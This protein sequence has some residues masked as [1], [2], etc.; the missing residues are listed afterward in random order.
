MCSDSCAICQQ[1][2]GNDHV[3]TCNLRLGFGNL[4][5]PEHGIAHTA[6]KEAR[7]GAIDSFP[8]LSLSLSPPLF[9][10]IC[11]SHSPSNSS[12]CEACVS[13]F[14]SHTTCDSFRS[15][16]LFAL[17]LCAPLYS[18]GSGF[19]LPACLSL[20][21]CHLSACRHSHTDDQQILPAQRGPRAAS[22]PMPRQSALSHSHARQPT[23]RSS[24]SFACL[25]HPPH[26]SSLANSVP[27]QSRVPPHIPLPLLFSIIFQLVI[28][29]GSPL[30]E[31]LNSIELVRLLF[32]IFCCNF[33]LSK[34]LLAL[35]SPVAAVSEL[36]TLLN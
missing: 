20:P 11:V 8:S 19:H 6:K 33:L 16:S 28:P 22:F 13:S 1:G 5:T 18:G 31:T 34:N 23:F 32:T 29:K 27:I 4:S 25:P 35:V 3:H 15:R 14:C 12:F 24:L 21:L 7:E 10:P 17:P 30:L 26:L 9:L 36:P 2:R